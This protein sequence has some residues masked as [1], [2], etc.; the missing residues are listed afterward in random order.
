MLTLSSTNV[1]YQG[2]A[3]LSDINLHIKQGEKLALVGQSGSGKTSL[4]KLLNDRLKL[5]K[6]NTA[7]ISQDYALVQ[8]LSVYHNVYM[9]QLT[10]RP[11]WYNLFNL[12]KPFAEPLS[13]VTQILEKVQLVD[14]LFQPVGELSGGQQQRT[15][16][17]RA[18]MQSANILLADEPVSSVDERQSLRIMKLLCEQ[19]D[20]VI[21]SL[22]DVDLA[23]SFCDRVIGIKHG[24]IVIDEAT[25]NLTRN[26]LLTLYEE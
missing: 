25:T 1:H 17:A 13:E 15:A 2:K 18:V 8:N 16:I 9:G 19:F 6:Y 12:I 4:L 20:S 26:D 11:T 14:K 7:Y 10:Q 21:F 24:K 3:A 5:E 23:L 22:H